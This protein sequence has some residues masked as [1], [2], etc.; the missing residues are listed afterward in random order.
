MVSLNFS[1]V[2]KIASSNLRCLTLNFHLPTNKKIV[3]DAVLSLPRIALEIYKILPEGTRCEVIENVLYML[4]RNT[5]RHQEVTGIL[6][7]KNVR[8]DREQSYPF[9]SYRRYFQDLQSAFQPDF[10]IVRN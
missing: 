1:I 2:L 9:T 6:L 4:P 5:M 10:V 3:I 8:P 7:K